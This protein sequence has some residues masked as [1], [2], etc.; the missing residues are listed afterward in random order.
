MKVP[1]PKPCANQ[2]PSRLIPTEIDTYIDSA[3]VLL[4]QYAYSDK[5]WNNV[6]STV[7]QKLPSIYRL[8]LYAGLLCYAVLSLSTAYIGSEGH[9][10][11]MEFHCH[12]ARLMLINRLATP[13]VIR[14]ATLE[15]P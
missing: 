12:K 13:T 14:I 8:L 4:L 3:D 6:I 11:Q 5:M 1:G 9:I 2:A 7:I 15:R 10:D